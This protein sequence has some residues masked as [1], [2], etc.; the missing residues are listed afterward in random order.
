LLVNAEPCNQAKL[1]TAEAK[2]FP[3]SGSIRTAALLKI[4]AKM[5]IADPA[6]PSATNCQ[7]HKKAHVHE[8]R[9]VKSPVR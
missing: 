7:W 1:S 6:F 8:R 3:Q 2:V 9:K 5:K 4:V